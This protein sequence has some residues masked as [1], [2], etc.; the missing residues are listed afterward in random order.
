MAINLF[1]KTYIANQDTSDRPSFLVCEQDDARAEAFLRELRERGG[2]EL[3]GR[4]NRVESGK[5]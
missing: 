4:V 5:E 3:A 1:T 2:A